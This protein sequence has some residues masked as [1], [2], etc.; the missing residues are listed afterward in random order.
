LIGPK[1]FFDQGDPDYVG[2]GTVKIVGLNYAHWAD[3]PE[4]DEA[5]TP[6]TIGVIALAKSLLTLKEWGMDNIARH[7]M[8]LTSYILNKMK[9]LPNIQIFGSP[10]P[11][12]VENRLGVS[13][14]NVVDMP[15]ALTAAILNYEGGIGVRNGCFCAHPYIKLLMGLNDEEAR[16][17]EEQILHG[18]RSAIPGAVRASFGL[19]NT[20][21]E[22]DQFIEKLSKIVTNRY[23]GKYLLDREKGEYHP[24][25]YTTQ[26]DKYF[27]L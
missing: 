23:E 1:E 18:D 13:A 16:L 4:R 12:V 20:V 15:H 14:F 6:N 11:A 19:Y 7:E 2:G 5:G 10:D 26:F 3:S 25:G 8:H 21:G 17:I 27:R 24:E 9:A 22:I